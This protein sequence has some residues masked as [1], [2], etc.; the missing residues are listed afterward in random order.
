MSDIIVRQFH[1]ERVGIENTGDGRTLTIRAVP[2]D[3][4]VP[5]GPNEVE[6][7]DPAAFD[8][9]APAAFRVKLT[10]GHPKEGQRI[11]DY[12]VGGLRSMASGP[13]GLMVEARLAK[14]PAADDALALYEAEALDE[15]SVGFVDLGTKVTRRGN[16]KVL[17]RVK[18][19]LDHLALVP[20]GA[21]G[22]VGAKVL[23]VREEPEVTGPRLADL[24]A[25][26]KRLARP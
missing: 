9:Q 22:K 13:D 12:L 26:A 4:E 16:T 2:W 23:A 14:T 20:A 11:N 6:S 25:W 7:F 17:R 15:V 8:H 5:V 19:N 1:L 18:A 10:L 21:Y 24:E 3:V